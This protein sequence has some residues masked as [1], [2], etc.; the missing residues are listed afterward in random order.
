MLCSVCKKNPAKVHLTQILDDKIQKVDL[1]DN[2][3]K[4]KG[5]ADPAGFSLADL[6]LGLGAS[7]EIE[8]PAGAKGG[9]LTCPACGFTQGDFKKTG[10][11]GCATCYRTFSE[12]LQGILKTM[13]KGVRHVGKSPAAI[14]RQR[15]ATEDLK[16]LQKR[17]DKAVSIENFEEA[18]AL[19]DQM[20]Q[21]RETAA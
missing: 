2:C 21:L 6:L 16:A 12:G 15:D 4:E 13:H 3:S 8:K 19:R 7:Q 9:D 10:R 11:L 17:L 5:V 14:R 20:R 18:A 1:C